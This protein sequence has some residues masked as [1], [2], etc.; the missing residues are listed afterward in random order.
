MA[1]GSIFDNIVSLSTPTDNVSSVFDVVQSLPAGSVPQNSLIEII[2]DIR[3]SAL[4]LVTAAQDESC[5]YGELL[6]KYGDFVAK[7]DEIAPGM[8]T[9]IANQ[10]GFDT[11]VNNIVDIVNVAGQLDAIVALYGIKVKLDSLYADKSVLDSL[12]AD[13][14][15]LDSL[16]VDKA[17]LDSLYAAL[18]DVNSVSAALSIIGDLAADL[19]GANTVGTVAGVA[20]E[21]AVVGDVSAAGVSLRADIGVVAQSSVVSDMGV[22]ARGVGSNGVVNIV[23][24]GTLAE[25]GNLQAINTVAGIDNLNAVTVVAQDLNSMDLNGIADVTVVANDLVLGAASTIGVVSG[26]MGDVSTVAASVASGD[27]AVAAQ[28]WAD[29]LAV[30]VKSHDQLVDESVDVFRHLTAAEVAE[31][32]GMGTFV[33]FT[34]AFEA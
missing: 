16:Y 15:T 27:M 25:A 6:V 28:N 18:S 31:V 2:R 4:D 10:V 8:A 29:F 30:V 7:Y 5:I 26:G 11:T 21:V 22:L 1:S 34:T 12:Y 17:K 3:G 33:D 32:Q 9:I 23:N 19:N 20:N 14:V 24:V 13:K